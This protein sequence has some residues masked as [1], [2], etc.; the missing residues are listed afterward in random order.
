M[1]STRTITV[2]CTVLELWPFKHL[3]EDTEFSQRNCHLKCLMG[4]GGGEGDQ[5]LCRKQILVFDL[6]ILKTPIK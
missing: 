2:V 4:G 3:I 6:F 5:F 1:E